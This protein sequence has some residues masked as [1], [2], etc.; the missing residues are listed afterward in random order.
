M[1]PATRCPPGQAQPINGCAVGA[2]P[3]V[4]RV[5]PGGRARSRQTAA[6]PVHRPSAAHRVWPVTGSQFG[7]P[8]PCLTSPVRV[9]T[10]GLCWALPLPHRRSGI[11][12]TT[13][14]GSA[15][16]TGALAAGTP[17]RAQLP[18]GGQPVM[19]EVGTRRRRRLARERM[20]A[21]V[22]YAAMG[23]PVCAGAYPLRGAAQAR[24]TGQR[25][26]GQP[27]GTGRACS[28]DRIGCPDPGAHP[29][30]P[31]WQ[32]QAT[33]DAQVIS[34]WWQEEP[35]A[36]VLLVTG[37][38]FDVLDVPAAAGRIAARAFA[39]AP[40]GSGPVAVCGP[41]RYL[42]FVATRGAPAD[43]GEWWSCQLDCKPGGV[44]DTPGLRWHCRDSYVLAP[45][46][47]HVSG[48]QVHW[49][50]APVGH[51]LPDSMRILPVLVDAC[52]EAGGR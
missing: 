13:G 49:L 25:N 52:E 51:P 18:W 29:I 31:A 48:Q 33:V 34:R 44:A 42:F 46:S 23:W 3:R 36:N 22:A 39:S 10:E 24:S 28:C 4:H 41:D 27:R 45:P 15:G 50:H 6:C 9:I 16:H 19:L 1:S 2:R 8:R 14:R 7:L 11:I 12:G 38:I 26:S 35:S 37:R 32:S 20:A 21:A 47:R 40:A 17:Q 30:S 43:E 5:K